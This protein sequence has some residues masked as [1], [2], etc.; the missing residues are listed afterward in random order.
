MIPSEFAKGRTWRM[1]VLRGGSVLALVCFC[2]WHLSDEARQLHWQDISAAL[3]DLTALQWLG[4]LAA[5]ALAFLAVA[6][7]ERAALCHLGLAVNPGAGRRAAMTA[8]A[9]SQTVGFGPV[10][11]AI[12]RRRLLPGLTIRQSAGISLVITLGFFAG[13]G[14]LVG[15]LALHDAAGLPGLVLL[16][17][18]AA[19][20]TA[21]LPLL[22]VGLRAQLP[23]PATAL[24]FAFWLVLDLTA[25]ALACWIVLPLPGIAF[26]DVFPLFLVALG[27]GLASGSPAGTGPFEATLLNGLPEADPNLVVA[28][29]V[30]F[31]VVAYAVPALIG[32]TWALAGPVLAPPRRTLALSP[33]APGIHWLRRLP[34]AEAQLALQGETILRQTQEGA[35]WLTADLP[36]TTAFIGDPVTTRIPHDRPAALAAAHAT[37]RSAVA[38]PCL[39]RITPRLAATARQS[40]MSLLALSREAILDPCRFTLD[41]SARATLRRKLRHAEQAGVVTAEPA[42]PSLPELAQVA[43]LWADRHGGERGLTMG[44]FNPATLPHQRLFTARDADGRLIAFVTFHAAQGEWVLDLIRS[45]PDL[46][47]GTLY[48]L[49]LQALETARAEGI[50]RLSLAC[51]PVPGFGLTGPAGRIA[52]RLTA[53]AE[54]LSQFKQAFKP[55]WELR[56]IAAPGPLR[57]L[58]AGASIARAIHAPRPSRQGTRTTVTLELA[59]ETT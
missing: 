35:L 7:Q 28:G 12:V 44:R 2:L 26:P 19:L 6:G 50:P 13:L 3:H 33:V 46:P 45:R 4:G 30:A 53:G 17:A 31:R 43:T 57:L 1:P 40:G 48:L 34:R 5:A 8:A 47:D 14:A 39:Y 20:A 27:A 51:A 24:R 11:G 9:I 25:L 52:R 58:I 29:I 38:I 32:A 18:I 56:Y 55:R 36:A 42:F 23:T 49:I 59:S 15:L 37:A 10:V 41:G 21:V 16:A 22:P 54:G